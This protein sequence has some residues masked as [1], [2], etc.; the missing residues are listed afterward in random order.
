[1]QIKTI[2]KT[3]FLLSLVVS[4]TTV[5]FQKEYETKFDIVESTEDYINVDVIRATDEYICIQI[6]N[7]SNEI[8]KIDWKNTSLNS[9]NIVTTKADLT[10][11]NNLKQYNKKYKEFFIGPETSQKFTIYLLD[12]PNKNMQISTNKTEKNSYSLNKIKYPAVLKLSIVKSHVDTV[13]PINIL[14]SRIPKPSLSTR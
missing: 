4:C 2:I 10:L 3:T 14:I 9:K 13:K 11:I 5:E 12:S 8:V 6:T 1:M 7:R